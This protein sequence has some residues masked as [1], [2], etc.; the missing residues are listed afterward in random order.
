MKTLE[1]N[2]AI[3]YRFNKEFVEKGNENVFEEIVSPDIVYHAHPQ[4]IAEG[5]EAFLD[6]FQHRLR[7]SIQNLKVDIHDIVAEGNKVVTL[8]AYHGI[9]KP[10]ALGDEEVDNRVEIMVM[11]IIRLENGR[12][13]EFWNLTDS[14]DIGIQSLMEESS[15]Y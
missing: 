10:E 1:R 13:V 12:F 4:G 7:P 8:K 14:Q 6:F 15:I 9:M 11:E 3:V 2:K 5:R